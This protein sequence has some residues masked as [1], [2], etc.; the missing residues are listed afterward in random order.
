MYIFAVE[1]ISVATS[2]ETPPPTQSVPKDPHS[3]Y[4]AL[5]WELNRVIFSTLMLVLLELVYYPAN[6]RGQHE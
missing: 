4:E 6:P 5:L 3:A 2:G 1:G